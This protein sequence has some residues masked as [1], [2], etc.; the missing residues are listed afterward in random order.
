M[1]GIAGIFGSPNAMLLKEMLK[2]QKHRG[3]DC[4]GTYKTNNLALGHNR[5]TIR[6]PSRGFQP[7]KLND[8]ALSYNGEI[9]NI[10]EL[11]KLVNNE[12]ECDSELLFDLLDKFGIEIIKKIKG[13]FAFVFFEK[14]KIYLARDSLGVKPLYYYK[15]DDTFYFASE[16]KALYLC[17]QENPVLE[18]IDLENYIK[19]YGNYTPIRQIKQVLPGSA[20]EIKIKNRKLN[21]KIIIYNHFSNDKKIISPKKAK[22][23][24]K[25]TLKNAVSKMLIADTK[26]GLLLSGGIDSTILASLLNDLQIS[27][28]AFCVG[29]NQ[30][31]EF[32]DAEIVA[33]EFGIKLK[34]IEIKEN[35]IIKNSQKVIQKM[36]TFDAGQFSTAIA[37]EKLFSNVN[38]RVVL[39]GE[40]ADELFGGYNEA[41]AMLNNKIQNQNRFELEMLTATRNMYQRQLARLDKLSLSHSIEARL[42]FLHKDFV[43]LAL[44][45]DSKLKYRQGREKAILFDSFK[46][47]FPKQLLN[48]H[49]ERFG[50]SSGV[51]QTIKDHHKDLQKF[52]ENEFKKVYCEQAVVLQRPQNS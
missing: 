14:N 42:P 1:C 20:L 18:N 12:Y 2:V 31:N 41:F 40:G 52:V 34:T 46:E 11:E 7:I 9:Y 23:H 36:E 24:I 43:N 27:I 37:M 5:L 25:E 29:S 32:E 22:K 16:I 39:S 47:K 35:F 44:S 50:V 15:Y 4:F 49:K 28:P 17:M 21:E 6:G 51:Y 38:T 45:I 8:K 33:R 26:V 48:K 13:E 19:P 3:P 30:H 10:E